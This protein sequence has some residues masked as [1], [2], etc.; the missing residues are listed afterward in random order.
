MACQLSS[1]LMRRQDSSEVCQ[2][3]QFP[4]FDSTVEVKDTRILVKGR[5]DLQELQSY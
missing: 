2:G 4:G 3:Y 5:G 1:L